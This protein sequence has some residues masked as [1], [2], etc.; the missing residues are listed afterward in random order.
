[1]HRFARS[2]ALAA[3]LIAGAT[4]P[5]PAAAQICPGDCSRDGQIAINE[6]MTAVVLAL[7]GGPTTACDSAD[8]DGDGL[9]LVHE[10]LAAVG[11]ALGSCPAPFYPRDDVLRLNQIQVLGSHNSYHIQAEPP[12]FQAIRDF[13]E[14]LAQTLEYTH[15]PLAEQFET[16]GVRQIELDVFADPDGGL[17]AQP[18]GLEIITNDPN[19]RIPELEAPGFKV[20]HVQDID[21]N[22]TCR[23]FVDCLQ[24][25]KA[26]SDAHPL[27]VPMTILV[28]AK[29]DVL[30]PNLG[31]DFV[32]PIQIGDPE[33]D[34]IDAE[35]RSVFPAAQLITPDDVRGA[36]ATL[37]EAVRAGEWPTLGAARGRVL[38]CLDNGG[39]VL[40]AYVTGHPSL[41][42]RVM[43]TSSPTDS[44]EGAFR[45]LNDPIADFDEIQAAVTAGFIVR[46]RADGDTLNARANDTTQRD[47]A[48]ASGAQ[49]VSTDYPVPNP[50]FGT[51]YQ[52]QIPGGAPARCNPLNAPAECAALD[53]ENPAHLSER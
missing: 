51:D 37:S 40:D 20:L 30:P 34:A 35:I 48:I 27:H 45:K 15:I 47:A 53:I 9:V 18:L 4:A 29:D 52:V 42:G 41:R 3:L 17:Y 11:A 36:R 43:F 23:T 5:R 46:T 31:F 32:V 50:A 8:V 49:F 39:D 33:L 24:V 28:E 14:A 38:F 21:Y 1:M 10:L 7:N 13:S 44:P 6:L 25:V 16:Q 26:W 22:T 2:T 12:V 19:A